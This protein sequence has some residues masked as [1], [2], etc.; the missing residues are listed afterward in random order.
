LK[1]LQANGWGDGGNGERLML[2]AKPAFEEI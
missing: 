1:R 2:E